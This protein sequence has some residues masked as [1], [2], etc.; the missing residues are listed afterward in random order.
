MEFGLH[1]L[2]LLLL[3][4]GNIG[5]ETLKR[6]ARTVISQVVEERGR[7]REVG[8]RSEEHW[9]RGELRVAERVERFP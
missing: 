5:E 2:V 8:G 4:G 7:S 6:A 3:S 9:P 1:L